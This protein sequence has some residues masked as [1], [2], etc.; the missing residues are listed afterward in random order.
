[1]RE[2]VDCRI[3]IFPLTYFK[4]VHFSVLRFYFPFMYLTNTYYQVLRVGSKHFKYI[5]TLNPNMNS[6]LVLFITLNNGSH[7]TLS[8]L[9]DMAWRI[10]SCVLLK[11]SPQSPLKPYFSEIYLSLSRW[12]FHLK[13]VMESKSLQCQGKKFSLKKVF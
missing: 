10:S 13:S 5:N 9:Y 1:M 7:L 11:L 12:V 6:R 8:K 4:K 2:R 3:S